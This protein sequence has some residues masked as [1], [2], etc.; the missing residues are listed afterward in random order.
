ME[1]PTYE[2]VS[3]QNNFTVDISKYDFHDETKS[4][5]FLDV[6]SISSSF[7][8]FF[9]CINQSFFVGFGFLCSLIPSGILLKLI[10]IGAGTTNG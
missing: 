5:L 6:F 3:Y 1:D 10:K 2:M 7:F 4:N 8:T 9:S